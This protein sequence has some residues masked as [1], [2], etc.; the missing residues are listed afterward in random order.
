MRFRATE[1][2]HAP[3]QIYRHEHAEMGEM[4]VFLVPAGLDAVG[5]RYDAVFS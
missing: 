3:Q 4:D 1:Q 2:S 5:M